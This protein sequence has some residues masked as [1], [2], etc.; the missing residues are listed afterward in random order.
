MAKRRE[1]KGDRKKPAGT[2]ACDLDNGFVSPIN[3]FKDLTPE[4]IVALLTRSRY[5]LALLVLTII[6]AVL[7]F[8]N[9]GFNS[10]W[11]DEAS[12]YTFASMSI[13]GIWEATTGGEFNPPLFYWIEHLMLT[14]GNN[15]VILRFVPAL[16]G[17]LT[18]PLVYWAGKEFMDRNVGI[19][20]AAACTFSP[21]L[22]L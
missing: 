12:T 5:A 11:L 2:D 19:I 10:L 18:I 14:F 16:L 8:F 7:R 21:F 9:L 15:E 4:N 22:I 1:E 6:G 20:A 17:I 13:P 3:T